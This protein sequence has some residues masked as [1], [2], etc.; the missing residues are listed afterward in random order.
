MSWPRNSL[1]HLLASSSTGLSFFLSLSPSLLLDALNISFSVID[2]FLSSYTVTL[3]SEMK[4]ENKIFIYFNPMDTEVRL[5][6]TYGLTRDRIISSFPNF[7]VS[8]L[9]LFLFNLCVCRRSHDL[10]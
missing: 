7:S 3:D 6:R 5:K 4:K 8:P 1:T 10:F 2:R 9:P